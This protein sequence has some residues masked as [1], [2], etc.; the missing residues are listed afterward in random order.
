MILIL[1]WLIK[2]PDSSLTSAGTLAP[3]MLAVLKETI[4]HRF[5]LPLIITSAK[6]QGILHPDAAP[7]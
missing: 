6:H 4:K 3:V 5:M 7:G 2:V 1:L